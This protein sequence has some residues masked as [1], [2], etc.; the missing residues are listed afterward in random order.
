[1]RYTCIAA[2]YNNRYQRIEIDDTILNNTHIVAEF[3]TASFKIHH[4]I[5]IRTKIGLIN[6]LLVRNRH[7]SI[8]K[9]KY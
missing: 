3:K 8:F 9:I 2:I 7:S 6:D 5:L 4:T 1:M